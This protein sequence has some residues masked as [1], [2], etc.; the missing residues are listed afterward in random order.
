MLQYAQLKFTVLLYDGEQ[1]F[2]FQTDSVIRTEPY[3]TNGLYNILHGQDLE[4]SKHETVMEF[5][6]YAITTPFLNKFIPLSSLNTQSPNI[7][8]L[9]SL[10]IQ[11]NSSK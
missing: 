9:L 10:T 11:D 7:S 8:L 1:K 4:N 3:F 5:R 2:Y 6:N